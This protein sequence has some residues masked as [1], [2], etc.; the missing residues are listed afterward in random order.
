[1]E[2]N[3]SRCF[4]G[5]VL[6]L[7]T[8]ALASVML[9]AA[10]AMA[11]VPR[12]CVGGVLPVATFKL[13]VVPAK[14]GSVLPVKEVNIIK[15]G[16]KLRYEPVLLPSAIR[17]HARVAIV[18]APAPGS[19]RK[20]IEVL[21]A[22]PARETAEWTSPMRAS[23]IGVVFGPRGLSVKRVSSLV[24]NNPELV[25][26]LATYARQTA[27][28]NAL[29]DTLSQ[30][31][32]S[33]P[34][35]EDLN[36]AL[37]GF[38]AQYGVML[39]RI[40]PGTSTTEQAGA[41]LQ[42]LV[43]AMANYD[44]LTSSRSSVVQQSAGLAASV[45]ALFYGTP[46]GLAAGGAML[47]SNLRTMMFP[48]TDFRSAFVETSNPGGAELCAKDQRTPPRTRIAYLWMLEI[49]DTDAPTVSVAGRPSLPLSS[50]AKVK[51]TCATNAQLRILP[52]ARDWRLVSSDRSV[53]IAAKVS[54][55][56]G[57]DTLSFDLTHSGLPPGEYELAALW[58]WEPLKILGK[59]HLRSYSNFS[60]V[61]LTPASQ[62]RLIANTGPV[63]VDLTGADFEF[64]RKV[65]IEP[66]S[67]GSPQTLAFK[68]PKGADGGEQ[69]EMTVS[70]DTDSLPGGSYR[71]LLAQ[72]EGNSQSVPL[73]VHPA[74]PKI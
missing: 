50:E 53:P 15:A 48:G 21:K 44:P 31:E 66:A 67:G 57:H 71:L 70:V 18:I 3:S 61:K 51:L 5:C 62:D 41:L 58:D 68:L 45:A 24:K 39:P 55:D 7:G 65:E 16:D 72:A 4:P 56:A 30:Y 6:G 40:T 64:V 60:G 36:S 73:I 28:V 47:F 38:S 74:D 33:K 49:P 17:S 43:P 9:A 13:L 20:S 35:S 26:E 42:A 1:M 11:Y 37:K 29:V 14:G 19:K 27:T 46:V 10:A 22:K 63:S 34:G 8:M 69:L 2:K 54:V 59:I 12:P 23:V 25:P 32:D 52:R